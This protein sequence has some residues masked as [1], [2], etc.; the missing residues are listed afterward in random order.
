MPPPP[1][2]V[3]DDDLD[4]DTPLTSDDRLRLIASILARG[5][6]RLRDRPDPSPFHVPQ[7][8]DE[9]DPNR[10]AVGSHDPVTVTVR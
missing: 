6:R 5:L 3:Y 2:R 1:L 10:L 8:L 4:P 7:N 9:S